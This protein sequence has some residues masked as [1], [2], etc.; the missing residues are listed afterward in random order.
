M[1]FRLALFAQRGSAEDGG[2]EGGDG[3]PAADIP[4]DL[5]L[6]D[7]FSREIEYIISD[8]RDMPPEDIVSLQV[9]GR[10]PWPFGPNSSARGCL[11]N[12]TTFWHLQGYNGTVRG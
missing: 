4:A 2:G 7:I 9:S 8:R 1:F 6:F 3:G 12:A 11:C 10:F 5:Q